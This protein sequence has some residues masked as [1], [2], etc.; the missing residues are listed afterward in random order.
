MFS[1]KDEWQK[2]M[3]N[4]WGADLVAFLGHLEQPVCKQDSSAVG[5]EKGKL[6]NLERK[7]RRVLQE[8]RVILVY[9]AQQEC[10]ALRVSQES[11]GQQGPKVKKVMLVNPAPSSPGTRLAYLG[12]QGNRGQRG[13]VDFRVWDSQANL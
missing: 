6:E 2:N 4:K 3:G 1:F 8:T 12:S 7:V 9:Q 11:E 5:A 13:T 10:L